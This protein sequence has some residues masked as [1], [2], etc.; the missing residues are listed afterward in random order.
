MA[1]YRPATGNDAAVIRRREERMAAA[2]SSASVPS[3]T[4]A[5]QAT[6]KIGEMAKRVAELEKAVIP[7]GGTVL[8]AKDESPAASGYP[9]TW[10]RLTAFHVP[11][12]GKTLYIYERKS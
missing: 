3:G 4:R 6:E 2:V 10:V 11:M 5:F 8:M 9:G 12:T 1:K 7:V